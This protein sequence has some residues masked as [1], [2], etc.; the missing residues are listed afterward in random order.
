MQLR[1]ELHSSLAFLN[2]FLTLLSFLN[3]FCEIVH[4]QKGG[5]LVPLIP[6]LAAPVCSTIVKIILIFG[7]LRRKV[8]HFMLLSSVF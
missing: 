2:A 6:P 7:L 1:I 8:F 3:N 5:G 4:F